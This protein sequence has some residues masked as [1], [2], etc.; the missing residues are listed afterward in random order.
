MQRDLYSFLIRWCSD[1]LLLQVLGGCL[2]KGCP[3]ALWFGSGCSCVQARANP[4]KNVFLLLRAANS[5]QLS[6][7]AMPTREL[8]PDPHDWIHF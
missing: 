5:S 7:T 6:D 2:V 8:N 4:D 1:G 3:S